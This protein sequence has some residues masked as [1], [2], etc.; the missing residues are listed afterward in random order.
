M[1]YHISA[2]AHDCPSVCSLEIE[3]LDERRIGRIYGLKSNTY[4]A[5]VTCAKV[6]RYAERVHHPD[7]LSQPL[8]RRGARGE[9]RFEPVSWD[10]A[11]DAVAEAFIRATQAHG[12]EAVWPFHSG[13]TMGLIQRYG[14]ERLRNV[15]GYSGEQVTICVT[16]AWAGWRAGVGSVMGP[17]PREIAGADLVVA[18]GTNL[19]ATQ[20]NAMTHVARARRDRGAKLAVVDVYRNPTVEAADVSLII[21]PGTDG[22]LACA[23]MHVLL[24]EGLADRQYLAR[25]SDFGADVEQHLAERTPAWAARLTGLEEHAIIDFAR[26]YGQTKRSFIR[27]PLTS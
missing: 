4:A 8:A 13:G 22:A 26:L 17:D 25:Y 21:R 7:R 24:A 2:C 27:A 16:P 12:A 9:G 3:R 15:M 5:G 11:L 6:A 10:T 18:W 1:S 19:V 14:L 20:V 23:M